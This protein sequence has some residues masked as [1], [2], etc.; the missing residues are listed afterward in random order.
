MSKN[1][2]FTS[3]GYG[4]LRSSPEVQKE[5]ERIAAQ[6][7]SRYAE[8]LGTVGWYR[9]PWLEYRIHREIERRLDEIAPRD[10]L[11]LKQ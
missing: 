7:R 11:Y 10:A 1:A 8:E 2:P 6:V 3:D 5:R 4:K 9:K